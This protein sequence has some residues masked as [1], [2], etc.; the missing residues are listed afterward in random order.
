MAAICGKRKF[1]LK[2]AKSTFV[3]YPVGQ[4]FRRN[5]SISTVKEIVA[6]LCFSIF[7]QKFENTKWP[8]F[9]GRGNF[10]EK[11]QDYIAQMPGGSNISTKSPYLA[12]LRR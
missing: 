6:N 10:L 9:F 1:F 3:R 5:R 7:W 4:K 11:W 2:I 12:R 8:P